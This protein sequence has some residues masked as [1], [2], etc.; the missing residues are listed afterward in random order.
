MLLANNMLEYNFSVRIHRALAR[1]GYDSIIITLKPSIFFRLK[2]NYIT[3]HLIRKQYGN[4]DIPEL[5]KLQKVCAYKV[6]RSDIKILYASIYKLVEKLINEKKIG[7]TFIWNGKGITSLPISDVAEKYNFPRVYLELS[8]LPGKLF[9]DPKG[10]NALSLLYENIDLLKNYEASEFQYQAWMIEY[11]KYKRNNPVIPQVNKSYIK[12][13][14]LYIIDY[15]SCKS[16][17]TPVSGDY[18]L[19][20]KFYTKLRIDPLKYYSYDLALSTDYVFLPLQVDS[21]TQLVFNS[22]LSNIDAIKI[23]YN[24]SVSKSLELIVKPHPASFNKKETIEILTLKKKLGFSI[25]NKNSFDL[26]NNA[27]EIVTINSSVGLDGLILDKKVSFLGQSFY[28][29]LYREYLKNYFLNF[30]INI[31]FFGNEEIDPDELTRI[32][33]RIAAD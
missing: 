10:V 6:S 2:K 9:V 22:S 21:D 3:S 25:T 20:R 31:D 24:L 1:I 33:E 15:L 12:H 17:I 26:V 23:A 7:V 28:S 19:L 18:T 16:S 11:L 8:N 30:L 29:K 13:N 32:F 27:K 14:W 4:F 5:D